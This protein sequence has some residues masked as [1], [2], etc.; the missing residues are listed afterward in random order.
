MPA[1]CRRRWRAPRGGRARHPVAA[2]RRAESSLQRCMP[3][4]MSWLSKKRTHE[5]SSWASDGSRLLLDLDQTGGVQLAPEEVTQRIGEEEV[6]HP[7]EHS[8][9]ASTECRR[10]GG[11]SKQPGLGMG[12]VEFGRQIGKERFARPEHMVDPVAGDSELI[13]PVPGGGDQ[14]GPRLGM[15]H[16][17]LGHPGVPEERVVAAVVVDEEPVP[18]IATSAGF[19]EPRVLIRNMVGHE[20]EQ[21]PD[22]GVSRC[23]HQVVE[24]G[25][26]PEAWSR[27]GRS[28]W[29][30]TRD[31]CCR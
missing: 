18:G 24:G 6:G 22:V 9:V 31:S 20:V 2:A 8:A 12:A 26:A 27:P 16:V 3:R 7:V 4:P 19:G 5:K 28:P 30:R 10:R 23:D 14:R 21:D 17:D 25:V 29:C 15:V 13:E 1:R 11:F